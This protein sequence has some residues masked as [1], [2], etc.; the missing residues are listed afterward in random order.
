MGT[1]QTAGAA[2]FS[3]AEDARASDPDPAIKLKPGM[4]G[5]QIEPTFSV[6]GENYYRWS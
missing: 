4:A 6:D 2:R 5:H 1:S 3:V